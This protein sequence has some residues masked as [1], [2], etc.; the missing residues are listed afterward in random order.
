MGHRA[1]PDWAL[2]RWRG[3]AELVLPMPPNR[4]PRP[5]RPP[6]TSAPT[7]CR[8]SAAHGAAPRCARTRD[9]VPRADD[10]R[11]LLYCPNAE[12]ADAC[13]F[14]AQA[15]RTRACRSSPS[16]RRSTGCCPASSSRPSTSLPSSPGAGSP[17]CSSAAPR[18]RCPRHG[19]RHD[20]LDGRVECAPKHQRKGRL[21]AVESQPVPRL[22]PPDL[23]IQDELHLISG[24]LGTTVGLFEGRGR[25][26]LHLDDDGGPRDRAEDRRVH[27]HDETR[28]RAGPRRVRP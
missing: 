7:C 21:P 13:P 9:V 20:D 17:A 27:G 23:I 22:R 10:R 3:L 26:T 4:S 28:G 5:E 2:G 16:T 11:V 19:Y 18:Q 25:R 8:P 14:S 12:G 24:A 6:T 1:V 15:Q